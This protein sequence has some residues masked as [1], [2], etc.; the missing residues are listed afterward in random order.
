MARLGMRGNIN[1]LL[2][3]QIKK[4]VLLKLLKFVVF[5]NIFFIFFKTTFKKKNDRRMK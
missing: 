3:S 5:L 2:K 1:L 4:L